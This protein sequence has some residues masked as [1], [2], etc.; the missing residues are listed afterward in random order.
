M[1]R[2]TEK[3]MRLLQI[4]QLL[5]AHPEGLTRAEIARRL[6]INRS[7]LTK[8]LDKDNLPASIYVDEL[9]GNKLKIDRNAD[10]TKTAFNL[11][12]IMALHLATRLLATRTDKQNPHAAS[13]LRKLG[14]ALERF[15]TPISRHL[16]TSADVMD[17][18]AA[19]RDPVYLDALYKLT[20][21]WSA[22]RKVRLSHQMVDGKTFDYIFAPYF[23]E[24]YAVGQT[25]HVIGLREPP[26]KIRTF[27][28]ERLRA[29]ELLREEYTIP[30]TFDAAALLRNAWGIWY[31]E[32]EPV[33]VL[34]RF[35]PT[36]A[37]R[38][39]ETRWHRRQQHDLQADGYLLWR[40]TV[41]EPQEMLPWVRGWGAD[42]EVLAPETLRA[43]LQREAQ[44][45]SGLYG[46]TGLSN[47]AKRYYAHTKENAP[48]TEWQLL[49]DHLDATGELVLE[50]ENGKPFTQLSHAAALLHDIGKYSQAF[51]D[52]LR[53][54]TRQVDHATAGA[55]EIMA[56]FPNLPESGLAEI[57]SYC[58]AGH[59]SGLP[60]YGSMGDMDGDGT[61]LARREK[62]QLE[63]YSAYKSELDAT[64]LQL[65]PPR[66]KPT[67]FRFRDREKGYPGF[68]ISFLT[69]MVFSTLVDAD[70]LETERFMA[71]EE[72]LRGHYATI[73]ALAREFEHYMQRF[74]DPQNA[75]HRKRNETLQAC[76][77]KA[78]EKPGYFSLTVPTG[79]GKTLA[80]MAFALKHAIHNQLRR[81]IYVIP[82]TSIIEQNAAVL[83]AAFGPL[84]QENVL[85][86]HANLDWEQAPQRA[87]HG[88]NSVYEKLKLA[89]ENWDIPVI[90][91]TNVQF[92]ES[93]FASQKSRAR[94]VHNIANSVIIFDEVQMLPRDFL[95]PCLLAISEL[96]QNYGATVVFSTATQPAL[97]SFFSTKITFTELAPDPPA[98]FDFYRRVEVQ[99]LG[100]L[101][102]EALLD[103]LNTH[104]QALCIVNTR[105]HAKGLFDGLQGEGVFHLSTL[106]CPAHRKTTLLAIRAR[107]QDGQPCRVVSTQVMEA[108]IDVD[109][110]VGYRALAGLDSI[111]QA[112]GRVNREGK[113]PSGHIYVFRPQ[114]QLIKKTPAIIAQMASIAQA[115]LREFAEDPTTIE[116]INAYYQ[117]LYAQR[118]EK[119]FDAK[120]I[121][122]YFEKENGRPDFD[123]RTAAENFK[124]I[125]DNM[126]AVM[127]PYDHQARQLLHTLQAVAFPAPLLRKL[128]TYTV[129]IYE[130]E[131]L[132]LQGQGVIQTLHEGYH[133]LDER[134]MA[135][136][137]SSQT[138]LLLPESSGGHAVFF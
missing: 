50:L 104:Q 70:W 39:Q 102:D 26:G 82:Y 8:Y 48:E 5:W 97:E 85:E 67:R 64:T 44:R 28:I 13:A 42:V 80:S 55:R 62:K 96:V 98:L 10:L 116:A 63:D 2:A 103:K 110:P 113:Y 6:Q 22:G 37:A 132:A 32:A 86:H 38:V 27:K 74:V 94:K 47:I 41:A 60:D 61:L 54:S 73:D 78:K 105:R 119:D 108:G 89:A 43:Q 68:C 135:T 21:A 7:N 114:T 59:H 35:H 1:N 88:G 14:V 111:I 45:L 16:L 95:K 3:A 4:E 118:D 53:G 125:D 137:Y 122:Q 112:A 46:S 131:F 100:D 109:F 20:E 106:M 9:D 75:I 24:P 136:N 33:E 12:E 52:R 84:G 124:L 133:V 123:F 57:I 49:R 130:H 126:I 79:G 69:R 58:I 120:Q 76:I 83:R 138:G 101:T 91:T 34:L 19:F 51:Q 77:A 90:V 129:N 81:I 36:V 15:K 31:S 11:H 93:L 115:T 99:D 72:K 71:A 29:V 117:M 87:D 66:L 40:A 25:A 127:I 128:Q 23:I 30:D 17:E 92:F 65:L 107:L 56:L 121:L 18:D 134:W